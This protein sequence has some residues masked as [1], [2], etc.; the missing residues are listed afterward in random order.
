MTK[1]LKDSKNQNLSKIV[2]LNDANNA[3][4]YAT[5]LKYTDNDHPDL[6]NQINQ[7]TET[8]ENL[9]MDIN[10]SL[11]KKIETP[12]KSYQKTISNPTSVFHPPRDVLPLPMNAKYGGATVTGR[13]R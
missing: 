9:V 10:R 11:R 7:I 3:L 4:I 6:E 1:Y 8:R 2:R 13:V 5:L 12:L